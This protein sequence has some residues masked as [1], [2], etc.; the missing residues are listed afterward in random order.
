M[1]MTNP[2]RVSSEQID[3]IAAHYDERTLKFTCEAG[4]RTLAK[5][6][7]MIE[8]LVP[9]DAMQHRLPTSRRYWFKDNGARVLAVAHLDTV[10]QDRSASFAD[11][12]DG[13]I[14]M[15]GALDDRLGA[16]VIAHLLPRINPEMEYDL[17]FTEGEEDGESTA[18]FFNPSEHHDREYDWIIQFDRGGTDVVLYQYHDDHLE[19]LVLDT[20][21]DVERGAF[22][23]ISYLEHVGVKAMNWGVGYRDYH[24]PRG[25]AWL[26][27]TFEM[28][29]YFRRFHAENFGTRL[30]HH[31]P[32]EDEDGPYCTHCGEIYDLL[33]DALGDDDMFAYESDRATGAIEFVCGRCVRAGRDEE[34][35][36]EADN[37]ERI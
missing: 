31:G 24:G 29:E 21:A 30:R 7:G 33:I 19:E 6:L 13:P 23:D 35:R 17:L 3:H 32:G 28:V 10:C 16:Y 5:S 8:Y 37:E 36:A 22:S 18:E 4:P 15:S 20:G 14:V 2:L 9:L 1:D 34:A 25:H 11:T 26:N 27:D 12:A